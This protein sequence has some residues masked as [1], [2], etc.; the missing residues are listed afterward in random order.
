MLLQVTMKFSLV[1]QLINRIIADM[2]DCL[3]GFTILVS[4]ELDRFQEG[5]GH[6]KEGENLISEVDPMSPEGIGQTEPAPEVGPK[7]GTSEI[8]EN[9]TSKVT[10]VQSLESTGSPW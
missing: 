5:K 6:L 4:S 1:K 9:L 8:T 2:I 3:Y 10:H 7:R